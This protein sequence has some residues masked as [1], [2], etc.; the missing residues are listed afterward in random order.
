MNFCPNCGTK[1]DVHIAF[2]TGCGTKTG[3]AISLMQS[4]GVKKYSKIPQEIMI[5]IV[6]IV[7]IGIIGSVIYFMQNDYAGELGT[8]E[9]SQHGLIQDVLPPVNEAHSDTGIGMNPQIVV[10][11]AVVV[12]EPFVLPALEIPIPFPEGMDTSCWTSMNQFAREIIYSIFPVGIDI[13]FNGLNRREGGIT[14]IW[15]SINDELWGWGENDWGQLGTGTTENQYVPT[16]IINNVALYPESSYLWAFPI[17][18]AALLNDGTVWTWGLTHYLVHGSLYPVK[19]IN[20]AVSLYLSGYIGSHSFLVLR[21]DGTVWTWGNGFSRLLGDGGTFDRRWRNE[22]VMILD[23]VTQLYSSSRGSIW[24]NLLAHRADGS[25]WAWGRYERPG[26]PLGFGDTP[27]KSVHMF[28]PEMI[29]SHFTYT[30]QT[31]I[32]SDNGMNIRIYRKLPNI[33]PVTLNP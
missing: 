12:E 13:T 25:L 22:P 1:L 16:M 3:K 31:Y 9:L 33:R 4:S 11:S 21:S 2:C 26:S 5:A 20:D 7:C 15:F 23:N 24:E 14:N 29:L 10:E 19:M 6:V 32:L 18:G 28:Q 8:D 27:P 30:S 17:V